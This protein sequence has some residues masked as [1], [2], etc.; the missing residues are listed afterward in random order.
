MT[1]APGQVL[2][3]GRP[4]LDWVM[5][6]LLSLLWAAAYPLTRV[7]VGKGLDTGLPTEWVLPGRLV[8]GAALLW[9]VLI[10]TRKHLPPLSD[11]RRWMS[12]GGMGI[13]GSVL[14]FFLITTAQETVNSS[15]AALY[16]AAAPVFVA[17]G[18]NLLFAEER[19]TLRTGVGVVLGFVGVAVLFGP[20]A[21]AGL[22]S[23]ST[24]AQ[25]FLLL[26]TMAYA[27]ST[28][29]ARAAP[30]MDAIAFAAAYATVSAIA[31]LPLTLTVDPATVSANW[32]NWAAVLGLG[33][34]SSGIAQALYMAL[35]TRAGATFVSL[36]GYA[37]P[38]ISAIFGW[39]FFRE[40]Q[41]WNAVIAFGLILSGVWLARS[42]GRG[43]L[44]LQR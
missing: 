4:A 9:I 11:R 7:A 39:V 25:L 24:L 41:S 19:L 10:A 20:E 44:P 37:I 43:R 18:A 38:I 15:L 12:I 33:L 40:T 30:P 34:G 1:D 14:P 16:T 28:L 8:I 13:V 31:S 3:T 23:A 32:V 6:A 35:V 36:N 17:I 22:G 27:T 29:I 26:A 5:F 42:G 2:K 21:I